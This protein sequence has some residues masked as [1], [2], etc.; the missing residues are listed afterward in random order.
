ME[1]A[2]ASSGVESI[3]ISNLSVDEHSASTV[4]SQ[5]SPACKNG[6]KCPNDL[7]KSSETSGASGEELSPVT[8]GKTQNEIEAEHRYDAADAGGRGYLSGGE[9]SA[10]GSSARGMVE[11]HT[12]LKSL[13]YRMDSKKRGY[14]LIFNHKNFHPK[15]NMN[16][17]KGTD[18][19]RDDIQ[20]FF[21]QLNFIVQVFND[22]T[23]DQLRKEIDYYSLMNHS[24]YDCLVVFFLS[25]GEDGI[26]YAQDA[27]F[28][29]DEL[30]DA[31]DGHNCKSLAG[32]PKIFF[33]QA[34]RGGKLDRAVMMVEQTDSPLSYYK[35][36]ATA[37]IFT[38]WSTVP[39]YY[40]W[41]NT[42]NGSWFIQ[43][44]LRVLRD[45]ITQFDL[46]SLHSLVNRTMISQY[47][48]NT[49]GDPS[50]H[51]MKQ[52]SS[53]VSTSTHLLHFYPPSAK[54]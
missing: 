53:F 48:S 5:M 21:S 33:I 11:A 32:K 51:G 16:I 24:Q 31:F 9:S 36:P 19:D 27:A 8:N 52:V 42:T 44:L 47:E 12:A 10:F 49:P 1:E 29:H 17:R 23:L 6:A 38:M 41:R 15:V 37:D 2:N 34:C 54:H 3:D 18:K 40:S 28:R 20:K 13:Y 26:F 45:H 39:G 35:L 22:L 25:H 30:F 46:G 43:S 4:E 14:C 7:F 50:M